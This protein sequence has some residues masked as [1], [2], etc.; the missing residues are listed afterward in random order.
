VAFNPMCLYMA[1]A[2][3]NDVIAAFSGAAV[4]YACVRLLRAPE[5]LN[6]K[7]GLVLGGLYGLALMSKFNL[8]AV[9]LIIEITLTWI[10]WQKRQWRL[11]LLVNGL[12]V[13]AAAAVAG[14]WFVRN[15]SLYGEPTGFVEVTEL[16]G[17]RDPLDSFGLAMSAN[18]MFELRPARAREPSSRVGIR[19]RAP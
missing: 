16:W 2:I 17:V 3:N 1:G 13:V 4:V 19:S 15:I 6:W 11:W 7:W 8:A 12:L 14:W 5:G 18:A 9:L 10:A